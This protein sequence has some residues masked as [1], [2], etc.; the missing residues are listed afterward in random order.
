MVDIAKCDGECCEL[1]EGCYRYLASADDIRQSYMMPKVRGL[2][3]TYFWPV[4]AEP[5]D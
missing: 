5:D 4:G 1:A 2:G 3:C